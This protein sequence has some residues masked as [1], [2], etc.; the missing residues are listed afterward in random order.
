MPP[1]GQSMGMF[2]GK[3]SGRLVLILLRTKRG[4]TD[5][6]FAGNTASN[7][8]RKT[9]AS[10]MLPDGLAKAASCQGSSLQQHPT[11]E[12]RDSGNYRCAGCCPLLCPQGQLWE[13]G[14]WSVCRPCVVCLSCPCSTCLGACAV[15]LRSRLALQKL[16]AFKK[17][18][19]RRQWGWRKRN[20]TSVVQT[21]KNALV[22]NNNLICFFSDNKSLDLMFDPTCF[23]LMCCHL[24][25]KE[26]LSWSSGLPT[27]FQEVMTRNSSCSPPLSTYCFWICQGTHWHTLRD[28]YFLIFYFLL[29]FLLRFDAGYKQMLYLEHDGEEKHSLGLTP[30]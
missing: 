6:C 1:G 11:W 17:R 7:Q 24:P 15:S 19:Q 29:S 25:A 21:V 9:P 4:F 30:S 12:H 13:P 10:P 27:G 18:C 26:E 23:F 8:W 3:E 28:C 20:S 5:F 2:T 16:F 22:G 14:C